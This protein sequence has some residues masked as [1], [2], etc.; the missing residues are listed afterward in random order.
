MSLF[1]ERIV[2]IHLAL[3]IRNQESKTY[4]S[5]TCILFWAII[6]AYDR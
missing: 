3:L 5:K 6:E 2:P 1:G 4:S